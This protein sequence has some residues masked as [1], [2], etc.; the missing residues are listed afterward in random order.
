MSTDRLASHKV[1][2]LGDSGVGKT[3]LIYR[4]IKN[5]FSEYSEPTV[6]ALCSS[7][8]VRANDHDVLLE[9]WDTAGQERYRSLVPMYYRDAECAIVV[10]DIRNP[11]SYDLALEYID[12]IQQAGGAGDFIAI[13][14]NKVDLE[15]Q[16][17]VYVE[18]VRQFAEEKKFLLLKSVQN[19][20]SVLR[21]F[22][23]I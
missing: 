17:K 2:L 22:S 12:Q 8:T 3:S 6:G 18:T 5:E 21:N 7:K 4:Y 10:Y 16:R 15:P 19:Q 11:Q 13:V 1:V 14:G 9:I 23:K 20:V